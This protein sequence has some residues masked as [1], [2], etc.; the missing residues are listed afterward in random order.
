MLVFKIC[1]VFCMHTRAKKSLSKVFMYKSGS[2]PETK[3]SFELCSKTNK[4]LKS[5]YKLFLRIDWKIICMV[6]NW[7]KLC[8]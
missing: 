5:I 2:I 4:L 6:V 8:K 3:N 7:R 1:E